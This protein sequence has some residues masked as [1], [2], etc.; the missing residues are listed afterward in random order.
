[1]KN[2]MV[3]QLTLCFE[4]DRMI[5]SPF[6]NILLKQL[7]DYSVER[8]A[9]DGRAIF[10]SKDE[11]YV[12]ALGLAYLA[13]VLEFKKLTG[14]IK[15][16]EVATIMSFSKKNIGQN[17]LNQMFNDIQNS[18]VNSGIVNSNSSRDKE[19]STWIKVSSG[20]RSNNYNSSKNW[21]KRNSG[22]SGRS[23]W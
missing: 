7:T 20:Y 3:N 1:M 9:Q 17:G 19:K 23:M 16:M 6:D 4:R 12:D 11:H 8:K 2:F 15:D 21:G 5:L 18:Y 10:T 14:T 22:G 13:M